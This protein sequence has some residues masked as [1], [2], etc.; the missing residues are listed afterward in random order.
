[1]HWIA[2]GILRRRDGF[3]LVFTK[4]L[5]LQ[6]AKINQFE[7]DPMVEQNPLK[8][9]PIGSKENLPQHKKATTVILSKTVSIT[10]K[11]YACFY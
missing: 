7:Q 2:A 3:V 9:S 8:I 6:C 1:M 11:K 5:G 4:L 10:R